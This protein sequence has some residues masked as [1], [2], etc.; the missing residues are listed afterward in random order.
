MAPGHPAGGDAPS[1]GS[2]RPGW[3]SGTGHTPVTRRT[4]GLCPD[5]LGLSPELSPPGKSSPGGFV[6]RRGLDPGGVQGL[7]GG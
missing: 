3:V 2:P 1:P 6:L 4:L 7:G 5:N